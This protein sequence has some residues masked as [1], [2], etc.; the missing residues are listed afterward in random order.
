M[1]Q[2][3]WTTYEWHYAMCSLIMRVKAVVAIW[4][5]LHCTCV[6]D[7]VHACSHACERRWSL[8]ARMWLAA[9]HRRFQVKHPRTKRKISISLFMMVDHMAIDRTVKSNGFLPNHGSNSYDAWCGGCQGPSIHD[10]RESS[11]TEPVADLMT[12]MAYVSF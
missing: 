3:L 8:A 9:H 11:A 4:Y 6:K 10:A 5:K 7:A 12:V 1:K 2:Q